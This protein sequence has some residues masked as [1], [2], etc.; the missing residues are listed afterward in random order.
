MGPDDATARAD[1]AGRDDE[2]IDELVAGWP[3]PTPEQAERLRR[4]LA[5]RPPAAD[6]PPR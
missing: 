6:E 1:E 2:R 4:L 5:W 3:P